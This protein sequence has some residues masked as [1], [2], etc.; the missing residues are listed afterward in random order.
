LLRLNLVSLGQEIF[1]PRLND[2]VNSAGTACRRLPRRGATMV[3]F[4][5]VAPIFFMIV[6]GVIEFG[7]GLMVQQL[8]TNAARNGAR[9]AILGNSSTSDVQTS[10]MAEL[11]KF[12]LSTT[13]ATVNIT[14]NDATSP[15]LTTATASGTEI[16]V[17]AL[18]PVKDV[19]WLPTNTFLKNNLSAQFTMRME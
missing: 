7:R 2:S 17:Q 14:V 1:M 4:A 13:N 16:T 19:T 9:T 11:K 5:V 18:V 12:G 3:E 8:L 6:F 10:V 15:G